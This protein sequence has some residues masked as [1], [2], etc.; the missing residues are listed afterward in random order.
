LLSNVR[1]F[2]CALWSSW[3]SRMS[4]PLSVPLVF[5]A[6]YFSD[7]WVKAGFVILALV[8]AWVAGYT[9]WASEEPETMPKRS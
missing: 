7:A 6:I 3:L 1:N 2:I 5:I 8:S 4:G 9:V